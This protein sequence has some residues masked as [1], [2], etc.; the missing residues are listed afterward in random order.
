MLNTDNMMEVYLDLDAIAR[1][2][3]ENNVFSW[4]DGVPIGDVSRLLNKWC[5]SNHAKTKE[6]WESWHSWINESD[7]G[8]TFAFKSPDI[9]LLFKLT[10]GGK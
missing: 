2:G 6:G 4:P 7:G 10:W 9:A 1:I 3:K 5:H 8:V